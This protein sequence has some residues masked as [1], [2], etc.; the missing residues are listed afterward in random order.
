MSYARFFGNGFL[1]MQHNARPSTTRTIARNFEEVG[2]LKMDITPVKHIWDPFKKRIRRR[3]AAPTTSK[4]L[5]LAL[6]GEF[7]TFP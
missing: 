7:T 6:I 4:E 2:N 5:R 3:I 1:L